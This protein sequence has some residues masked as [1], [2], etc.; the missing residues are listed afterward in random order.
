M[1]AMPCDPCLDHMFEQQH[2]TKPHKNTTS[3]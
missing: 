2:V 1:Q 3:M